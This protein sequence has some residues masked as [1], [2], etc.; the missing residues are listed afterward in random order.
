MVCKSLMEEAKKLRYGKR[1]L[2]CCSHL[3]CHGLKILKRVRN[4][5][6]FGIVEV[7]IGQQVDPRFELLDTNGPLNWVDDIRCL[8][9][10]QE[11]VEGVIAIGRLV[12]NGRSGLVGGRRLKDVQ[13]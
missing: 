8:T 4:L 6:T 11:E 5:G 7:H 9:I 10:N 1:R 13:A 3:F 12:L 2:G